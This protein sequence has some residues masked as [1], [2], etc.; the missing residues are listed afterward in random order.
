ME[1]RQRS[2]V[3]EETGEL[4][5][6]IKDYIETKSEITRLTV[7]DKMSKAAG[8]ALGGFIIGFLFFLFFIFIGIAIAY[9]VGEYTGHTYIGFMSVAGFYLLAG[10]LFLMKKD[11]WIQKPL[12]DK[13][14]SNYFEDNESEED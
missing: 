4:L 2:T 7:L 12:A 10:I 5:D 8:I 6:H 9:V 1:S 14:I 13:I 3:E 11:Q